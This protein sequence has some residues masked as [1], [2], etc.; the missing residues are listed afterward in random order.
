MKKFNLL[1]KAFTLISILAVF[2]N[3]SDEEVTI[4]VIPD[5]DV[6]GILDNIDNCLSIYNEDQ[7]DFDEDGIGDVCDDDDDDVVSL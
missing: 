3:C 7:A 2:S 4:I 1:I 5:T 6:D